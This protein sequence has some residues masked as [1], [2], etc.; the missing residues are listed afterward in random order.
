M[1]LSPHNHA[2][3][4]AIL[5]WANQTETE[6]ETEENRIVENSIVNKEILFRSE[7]DCNE[8]IQSTVL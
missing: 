4:W 8:I 6:T 2:F 7:Q 3:L 1:K 5:A